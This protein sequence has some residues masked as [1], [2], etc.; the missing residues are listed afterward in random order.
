LTIYPSLRRDATSE[1]WRRKSAVFQDTRLSLVA[2][3]RWL[4]ERAERSLIA[5]AIVDARV[6]PYGIDLA[7][8]A[9]GNRAEARRALGLPPDAA[10]LVFAAN[11]IRDSPWRDYRSLRAALEGL[12]LGGRRIICLAL[13]D[14]GQTEWKG[15]AE[16]RFVPFIHDRGHLARHYQACDVYV[17]PAVADTFPNSVIEALACGVPVVATRVGGIPE[18]VDDEVTGLLVPPRHPVLLR[19]ALKRV[20]LDEELRTRMG[21]RAAQ[22]ARRRFHIDREV[23]AYLDLYAEARGAFRSRRG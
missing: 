4:L 23:K 5:P 13:G 19:G 14:G 16:I 3:C 11:G 10:V 6:I 15:E 12:D 2:P 20:L 22:Q 7:M 9:P 21:A 17:H 1:N 8:F 18:E